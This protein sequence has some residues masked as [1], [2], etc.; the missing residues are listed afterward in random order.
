MKIRS[1]KKGAQVWD[2]SLFQLVTHL[3]TIQSSNFWTFKEPRNWFQ[4]INSASLC[5]LACRYDNPIPTRFLANMEY[6]KIKTTG[7]NAE[8]GSPLIS[9]AN[10]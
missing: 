1:Y 6:F 10:R 8:V 9:S 3:D 4:K 7:A 2:F 5:S